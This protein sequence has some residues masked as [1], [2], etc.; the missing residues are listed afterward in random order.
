[1]VQCVST[2]DNHKESSTYLTQGKVTMLTWWLLG[3]NEKPGEAPKVAISETVPDGS[4]PGRAISGNKRLG[5]SG[6]CVARSVCTQDPNVYA[7]FEYCAECSGF[8]LAK[9]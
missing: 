8:I 7:K 4:V 9:L 2:H 6:C 1:M 3:R 5:Y